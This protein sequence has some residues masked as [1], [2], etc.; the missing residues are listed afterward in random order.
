MLTSLPLSFRFI[1]AALHENG[2]QTRG[3]RKALLIRFFPPA[4]GSEKKVCFP[5]AAAAFTL[6]NVI[7]FHLFCLFLGEPT[8]SD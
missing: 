4:P 1:Q 3:E 2:G 7:V 6:G 5:G 8:A